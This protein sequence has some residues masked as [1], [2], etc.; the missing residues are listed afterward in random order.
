[1]GISNRAMTHF[2]TCNVQYNSKDIINNPCHRKACRFGSPTVP[3]HLLLNR[4]H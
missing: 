2:L 3:V 1:M 4:Y